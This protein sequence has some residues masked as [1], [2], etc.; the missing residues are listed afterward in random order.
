MEGFRAQVK[1]YV[2]P[3]VVAVLPPGDATAKAR[4]DYEK[5]VFGLREKFAFGVRPRDPPSLCPAW[6]QDQ[7]RHPG[8]VQGREGER[9]A[10]MSLRT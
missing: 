1:G 6:G 2:I 4:A 8:L 7:L 5:V 10:L 3:T 9:R